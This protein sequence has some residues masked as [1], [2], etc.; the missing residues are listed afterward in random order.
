MNACLMRKNEFLCNLRKNF[1]K[2][3]FYAQIRSFRYKIEPHVNFNNF[4]KEE[5]F[6]FSKFLECVDE[7]RA[8]ATPLLTNFAKIWSEH[9]LKIKTK[10]HKV[11]AS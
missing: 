3:S 11:W 7:K 5:N 6:S 10:S 9:V 1:E 2:M 8:A 4:Q